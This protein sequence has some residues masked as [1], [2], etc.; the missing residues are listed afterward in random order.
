[1][2]E[3]KEADVWRKGV[4]SSGNS[5]CEGFSG[6]SASLQKTF[7]ATPRFVSGS[8]TGC[9]GLAKLTHKV[10]IT[11]LLEGFMQMTFYLFTYL[12]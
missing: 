7:A 1:M 11:R 8:V 9:W 12:V 4:P 2:R 3:Q 10:T 6:C 5:R